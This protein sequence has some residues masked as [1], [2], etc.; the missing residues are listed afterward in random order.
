M[1]SIAREREREEGWFRVDRVQTRLVFI[2]VRA[3]VLGVAPKSSTP[4]ESIR[5]PGE[6]EEGRGG[7][8]GF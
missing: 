2:F 5:R 3:K 6:V 1:Q 7:E 8:G 4:R